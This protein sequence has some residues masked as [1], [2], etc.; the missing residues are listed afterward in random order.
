MLGGANGL[1]L[2]CGSWSELFLLEVVRGLVS[3]GWVAAV[4]CN[5]SEAREASMPVPTEP[6]TRRPAVQAFVMINPWNLPNQ[7]APKPSC[8]G[9]MP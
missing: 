3:K 9:L 8:H 7:P 5:L 2:G 1:V 4:V 6:I